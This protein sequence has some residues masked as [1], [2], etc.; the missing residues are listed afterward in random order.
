MKRLAA[1]ALPALLAACATARG[2]PAPHPVPVL[3]EPPVQVVEKVVPVL[4]TERTRPCRR[5]GTAASTA[6]L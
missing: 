4:I 3:P 6:S 5:C 1:V 2:G